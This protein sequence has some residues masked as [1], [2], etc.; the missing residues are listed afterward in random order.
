MSAV[1]VAFRADLRRRGRGWLGVALLL[2]AAAG[3]IAGFAAGAR[4]TAS[5]AERFER[6]YR[7]YDVVV[8]NIP[9][10]G[11]AT[12]R[13]ADVE[14]LP[15]VSAS[16]RALIVFTQIAGRDVTLHVPADA[17]YGSVVQRE[18][19]LEGRRARPDA[20]R[21]VTL[22]YDLARD[23]GVHPGERFPFVEGASGLAP[24]IPRELEVVGIVAS[25][26]ELALPTPTV[27]AAHGTVALHRALAPVVAA[28]EP[29][30]DD[31]VF[32]RLEHG[33]RDIPEF[34]RALSALSGGGRPIAMFTGPEAGAD[35]HRSNRLQ[36][37]ALALVGALLAL[38]TL[39]VVG[40]LLVRSALADARDALVLH[41]LGMTRARQLALGAM[42]G[43]TVGAFA[44]GVAGA[45]AVAASPLFP[46]GLARVSEPSPGIA[47]DWIVLASILPAVTTAAIACASAGVLLSVRRIRANAPPALD[48]VLVARASTVLPPSLGVGVRFAFRRGR[49]P[50]RT[51]IAGVSV[52]VIAVTAAVVFGAALDHLLATPELY[53]YRWDL[54]ATNYGTVDKLDPGTPEGIAAVRAIPGIEGAAVGNTGVPMLVNGRAVGALALDVVRGSPDDALPPVV[55]GAPP[56][57]RGEIAMGRRTMHDLGVTRGDRVT[58][59]VEGVGTARMTVVGTAVLPRLQNG[60]ARLGEGVLTSN[61]SL[62]EAFGF[63]PSAAGFTRA[64]EV[65]VKLAP[66]ASRAA[67]EHALREA[68]GQRMVFTDRAVPSDLVNFGRVRELPLV[69]AALL[70]FLAAATLTHLLV[71]AVRS[72]R[73]DLAVLKTLGMSTRQVVV[74]VF[75]QSSV[76][77]VSALA[78][79]I[80]LGVVAGRFA[81]SAYSDRLGVLDR[82]AAPLAA[83]GVVVASAF[84]LSAAVSVLPARSASRTR[85]SAV[86]RAE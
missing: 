2:G 11:F 79:G 7:A 80:P 3:A 59:E 85:P 17:A 86:L 52:G 74:A 18:K 62:L 76:L 44:A 81:W 47:A 72:R 40:Q 27:D 49:V 1:L 4:R 46:T 22:G 5:A 66:G 58:V 77:T 9:D 24:G 41:A 12:F 61:D 63:D 26:N 6:E 33:T 48:S 34:R 56:V 31:G 35:L 30:Q 65:Y 39:L 67:V 82:Q 25:P 38:A 54:A 45:V 71:V 78:V 84:V 19:L 28:E 53:G 64:T 21:E 23:L 75:T 68:L 70:A 16:A 36:A 15:H 8:A 29:R 55:D 73:H 10:P 50:V 60:I 43:A 69:L 51:G 32:V 13:P 57:R 20:A 42:R 83:L 37:L 14:S